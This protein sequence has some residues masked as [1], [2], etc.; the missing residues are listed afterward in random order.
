MRELKFRAWDKGHNKMSYKVNLY[1]MNSRGKIDKAQINMKQVMNTIGFDCEVM[2]YTGLKDK[3][4]KE[5]YEGDILQRVGTRDIFQGSADD[6]SGAISRK[7]TTEVVD[8]KVRSDEFGNTTVGYSLHTQASYSE[9][10]SPATYEIIGN[11]YEN[12]EL[13]K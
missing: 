13:I 1:S 9:R 5:I 3:N 2:Q 12:S 10:S 8:L 6:V 7:V 4:G 11:I